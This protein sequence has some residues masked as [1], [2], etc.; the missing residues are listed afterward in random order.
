VVQ[1]GKY[2]PLP[3]SAPC[4]PHPGSVSL[5]TIEN[6]TSYQL[7]LMLSGPLDRDVTISPGQKQSVDLPAGTYKV[8]GRVSSTNVLPFYGEETCRVGEECAVRFSVR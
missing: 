3:A 1:G 8:V 7:R 5:R 6:G 2:T 4:I